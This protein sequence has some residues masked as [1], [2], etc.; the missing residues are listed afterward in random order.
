[1]ENV[2]AKDAHRRERITSKK[3]S[4]IA[5]QLEE[6]ERL[7]NPGSDT[8]SENRELS[9]RIKEINLS[10]EDQEDIEKRIRC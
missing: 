6:N 1:L 7:S 5:K 8:F 3:K 10:A 9:K 2:K 4:E